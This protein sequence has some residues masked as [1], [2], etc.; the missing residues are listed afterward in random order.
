MDR[1]PRRNPPCADAA[2]YRDCFALFKGTGK[3]IA[4]ARTDFGE[5]GCPFYKTVAQREKEIGIQTEVRAER[6]RKKIGGY[7][8]G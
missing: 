8:H 2:K 1:A 3:C 5:K 7:L 6:H 4:L